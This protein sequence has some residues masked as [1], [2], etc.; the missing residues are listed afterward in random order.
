MGNPNTSISLLFFNL[1]LVF[2]LSSGDDKRKPYIVYMGAL[3]SG[4]SKI[5]LSAVHD[6]ILSQAIGDESIARQSKIH[7][8]GRS[9]NALAAKLL[10]HEAKILSEKAGVVSVFP[11][12][13]RKLHTTHSWDFLGMPITVKR[14]LQVESDIIIGLIDSGIWVESPSFNDNGIGPPPAK[15]KG[16][17]QKGLNFTGCNNKVIGAQAFSLVNP[18]N[19]STSP[20]DFDGHGTHTSSIV[21]GSMHQGANLYGLLNGTARGGVPAAR[22][23]MYKACD[24]DLCEDVDI[25]AAFDAAIADGVDIMSV[26]LGAPASSYNIDPIAIGSF[27]AM[28]KGILTSC[29]AGNRGLRTM[30][31][32]VAPW[33]LTVAAASTNRHLE[34]QLQLGDGQ[35][36]S[37][38]NMTCDL[39][40]P[41]K[42]KVKDKILYCLTNSRQDQFVQSAGAKGIIFSTDGFLDVAFP[43]RIPATVV[44]FSDINDKIGKYIN[45]TTQPT[46]VIHPTKVVNIEDTFVASFSSRG[47]QYRAPN[48][49]KPDISA[50]GLNILAA[51]PPLTSISG[52]VDDTRTSDYNILSGT[53]MSCPHVSAAAAYV[54]SFHPDWSPAIVKSALMTTAKPLGVKDKDAEYAYGAGMVDPT[55]ALNPGLVFDID[56]AAYVSFLCKIGYN[57]SR[58][59]QITGNKTN[60]CSTISSTTGKDGLNY[61]TI[62]IDVRPNLNTTNFDGV[63]HRTAMNVGDGSATY[64]AQIESEKGLSIEVSPN[65]LLFKNKN[66]KKSFKVT[67]SGSYPK[68]ITRR[69]SGSIIWS[70]T[71]HNVKIPILV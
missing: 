4:G 42:T 39:G 11:S 60:D 64:K 71:I 33:I 16:K 12:V 53:S 23:A 62:N 69:L 13:N 58:L 27:H 43:F 32:N 45:L 50:P 37:V 2:A 24:K 30:V 54:K 28:Q 56:E 14:N 66:E 67:L 52:D 25:L 21:A 65:I 15:W 22:I 57:G 35:T 31:E 19:R 63:Y 29:S 61:P 44:K 1:C 6:N 51:F 48:L 20:A 41:N 46:A 3:P 7:T 36:F 8:Y 34:T 55:A 18:N 17:C 68:E 38:A 59:V 26:S 10:P 5:S 49:L 70:D 9:F 47:P 40:A